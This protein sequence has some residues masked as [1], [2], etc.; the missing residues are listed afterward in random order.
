M[1][2]SRKI[3]IFI[4]AVSLFG[5]GV[6]YMLL[7]FILLNRFEELDEAALRSKLDNVISSYQSELQTMKTGLL[8]YSTWDDT[9]RFMQEAPPAEEEQQ[10]YLESNFSPATYAV[11]QFDMAALLDTSGQLRYGASIMRIPVQSPG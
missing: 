3:I 9:Y 2:L 8:K 10:A 5:L 1:K 7:H 4:V 11:N 6:T